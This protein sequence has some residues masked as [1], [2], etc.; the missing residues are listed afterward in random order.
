MNCKNLVLYQRKQ[1]VDCSRRNI[2]F[3]AD[4]RPYDCLR[5]L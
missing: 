1:L 2:W 4:F 5:S 3:M